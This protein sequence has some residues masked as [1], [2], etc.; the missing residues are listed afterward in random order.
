M[1]AKYPNTKLEDIVRYLVARKGNVQAASDMLEK[2]DAWRAANFPLKRSLLKDVY[3]SKVMFYHGTARDGT[4]VIYF[5]GG[6]YDKN[7]ASAE[8]HC[9][10]AAHCIDEALARATTIN[11]TVLV[12]TSTVEGGINAPAD[13]NFIKAFVAVLSDNY[14]ERLKR[15]VLYPF[16]WWGRTIWSMVSVFL[17]KRTQEKVV[18]LSGGQG[19]HDPPPKEL[20][21]YVDAREIPVCCGGTDKSA[22]VDMAASLPE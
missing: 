9:L 22:I 15:L 13:M 21:D 16:P 3:K 11:V 4:P 6:L 12:D 10:G 7:L 19:I 14:P 8:V 20:F 1:I 2:C 17:D 5:R 18:L